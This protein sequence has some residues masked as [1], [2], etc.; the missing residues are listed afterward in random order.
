MYVFELRIRLAIPPV[1]R[2]EI[3]G[4]Q[5]SEVPPTEVRTPQ[6]LAGIFFG[7]TSQTNQQSNRSRN[8]RDYPLKKKDHNDQK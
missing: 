8:N 6:V 2:V 4:I 3:R 5:S 1:L 7:R